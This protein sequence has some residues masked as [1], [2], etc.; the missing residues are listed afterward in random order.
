MYRYTMVT[1]SQ[2]GLDSDVGVYRAVAHHDAGTF[3]VWASVEKP[4]LIEVG[5]SL[6]IG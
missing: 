1:R 3:G 6:D 4:G 2:P 5:D